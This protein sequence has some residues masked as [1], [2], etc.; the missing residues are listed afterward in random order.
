MHK[1]AEREIPVGLPH[2]VKDKGKG[3]HASSCPS[4]QPKLRR[5][6]ISA[7]TPPTIARLIHPPPSS[8][9]LANL[10]ESWVNQSA[11]RLPSAPTSPSLQ[12]IAPAFGIHTTSD[13]EADVEGAELWICKSACKQGS[14][15]LFF[16]FPHP[17][18]NPALQPTNPP[19]SRDQ[20]SKN[21]SLLPSIIS[22]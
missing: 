6:S 11:F 7:T 16:G 15:Q 21:I 12:T 5:T 1:T 14:C 22:N 20:F 17:G 2:F 9:F 4:V 13:I 19:L 18:A 8:F 10:T 3:K